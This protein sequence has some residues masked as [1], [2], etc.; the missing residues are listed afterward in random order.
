MNAS[1]ADEEI[2]IPEEPPNAIIDSKYRLIHLAA[3][4]AKQIT[5][6]AKPRV[7]LKIADHKATYIALEEIKEQRVGF[8]IGEE[9]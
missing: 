8:Q 5:N 6:G 1:I 2:N 3:Q 7:A 9:R 4:R